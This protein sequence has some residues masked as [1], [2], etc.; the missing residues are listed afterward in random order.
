MSSRG[1]RP[2]TDTDLTGNKTALIKLVKRQEHKWPGKKFHPS[3]ASVSEIKTNLRDPTYGFTTKKPPVIALH[4]PKSNR[5]GSVQHE[6]AQTS[7]TDPLDVEDN[8]RSIGLAAVT[9]IIPVQNPLP[10]G[11]NVEKSNNAIEIPSTGSGI[12]RI[13]FADPEEEGWKIPFVRVHHGEDLMAATFNPE[14]LECSEGGRLKLFID[15]LS[16]PTSTI[17]TEVEASKPPAIPDP[18]PS[19]STEASLTE[20][21]DNTDPAV[22]FLREKLQIRE[23]YK[24]FTANRGRVLSNPEAVWGWQFAVDFTKDYHKVKTPVKINKPSIQSALGIGSTWLS[25]AHTAIEIIG[26]ANFR[27]AEVYYLL[28]FQMHDSDP[29]DNATPD[30]D[31]RK[32]V[33]ATAQMHLLYTQFQPESVPSQLEAASQRAQARPAELAALLT[34][35][36]SA[37]FSTPGHWQKGFLDGG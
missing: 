33:S 19:T 26:N 11:S 17:K 28:R 1:E 16:I 7:D 35:C 8:I 10:V 29:R 6:T 5:L 27:E 21:E 24:S 36:H 25:N 13:S 12:V 2:Y 30:A 37:Y 20:L 34:E 31:F 14:A 32:N 9:E 23:G 15:N 3:K 22:K 18:A 4:P